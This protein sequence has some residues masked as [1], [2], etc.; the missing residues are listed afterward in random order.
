MSG[1]DQSD[2][3][4]MFDSDDGSYLILL[5]LHYYNMTHIPYMIFG[6]ILFLIFLAK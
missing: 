3:L 2:E 5:I 4:S 1:P 6:I